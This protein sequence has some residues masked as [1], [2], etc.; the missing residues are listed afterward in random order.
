MGLACAGLMLTGCGG[1]GEDQVVTSPAQATA[2]T[3]PSITAP[4]PD[5]AA[6]QPTAPA[7]SRAASA[8]LPSVSVDDVGAGTK[9]DLAALSPSSQPTL[10]WM[11]APH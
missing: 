4:A 1:G 7:A 11:W 2:S 5:G 3:L 8:V 10:V 6:A 9:V